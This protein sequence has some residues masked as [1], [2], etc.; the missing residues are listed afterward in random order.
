MAIQKIF[1]LLL[2]K[3]KRKVIYFLTDDITRTEE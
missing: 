2:S 1:S 3:Q